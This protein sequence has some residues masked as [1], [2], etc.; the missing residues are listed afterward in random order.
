MKIIALGH[1]RKVGKN[2]TAELL[3]SNLRSKGS[4]LNIQ[5]LSFAYKL[6]KVCQDLFG[7]ESPEY[8]E[9][10]PE[11]KEKVIP[12]LGRSPRDIY[13]EFGN[14]A[15]K[16]DNHVWINYVMNQDCDLLLITDLRYP[17]EAQAVHDKGGYCIK[18]NRDVPE[19]DDVADN[20]LN[21]YDHWD[22]V[23]DNRADMKQ[24]YSLIEK[25]LVPLVTNE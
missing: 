19:S 4:T 10:Y 20:A 7:L 3:H 17:N 22:V 6:K 25:V 11:Q 2:K 16:I 24:L 12:R 5:T 1:K 18:I 13:I 23:L 9:R 8:Y 21:D 15:R 14:D